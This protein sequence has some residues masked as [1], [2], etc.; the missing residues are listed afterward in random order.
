ML[1]PADFGTPRHASP[2]PRVTAIP[3]RTL[4]AHDI[5][6]VLCALCDQR[7]PQIPRRAVRSPVAE[8]A[9]GKRQTLHYRTVSRRAVRIGG[10][11]EQMANPLNSWGG[12]PTS[13]EV[14]PFGLRLDDK[15][16]SPRPLD[17]RLLPIGKHRHIVPSLEWFM[18]IQIPARTT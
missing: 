1:F 10:T 15:R 7:Q 12:N 13:L 5:P 4:V 6:A 3:G 14:D 8:P 9:G 18:R 16:V 11:S 2:S 17:E